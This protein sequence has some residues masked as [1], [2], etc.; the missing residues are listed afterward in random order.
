MDKWIVEPTKSVNGILFGDSREI[1]RKKMGMEFTEF[2][3]SKFSKN[4]TD[5]FGLCHIFYDKDNKVEAVEVFSD[6]EVLIGNTTV[7]PGGL[8]QLKKLFDDLHQD[9]D[10]YISISNSV[11]VCLESDVIDCILFGCKDYYM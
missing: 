7:F 10:S 4:T 8:N 11:G 5:D 6:V 3:K 1:A 2:K 9:G